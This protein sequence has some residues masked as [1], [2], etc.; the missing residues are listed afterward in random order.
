MKISFDVTAEDGNRARAFFEKHKA[1]EF[2]VKRQRRNLEGKRAP[3]DREAFWKAMA[4]CLLTTQQ[5]SGPDSAIARFIRAERYPL[6]LAACRAARDPGAYVTRALTKFG[7]IRRTG[8]IG[9]ELAQN[10][11]WLD[12]EGGWQII[13]AAVATLEQKPAP[14][15]E[16]RAAEILAKHL[17]G[18]GPKQSRNVLQVLG[19]TQHEV[20]IDSR[21]TKWLNEFGFP[22]KLSAV[23]LSDN[24]YYGLVS[25]GFQALCSKAEVKPCVMDAAIFVS[26]DRAWGEGEVIW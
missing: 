11:R 25:D 20:P 6:T 24:A 15:A 16:R 5:R 2:V 19:L 8:N 14:E 4:D 9:K 17:A 7:G 18:L 12:A 10:L 3:A 1:S 22:L 23:A 13:E 21:V 26:F